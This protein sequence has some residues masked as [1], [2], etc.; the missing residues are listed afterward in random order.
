[1][2]SPKELEIA[3][4]NTKTENFSHPNQI[5]FLLLPWVLLGI[6]F[7]F[8]RKFAAVSTRTKNITYFSMGAFAIL[9]ELW[10]DVSS[11]INS[12]KTTADAMHEQ[13]I[14]GFDFCRMNMYI[15]GLFLVIRKPEMVKWIAAT[16]LFGGYSTLIDHYGQHSINP[17]ADIHSLM[18]HAVILSVIPAIT[19][20]MNKT[21]YKVRNL[22]QA[23]LF[24]WTLVA[25]MFTV[26]VYNPGSVAGEL[27]KDRMADNMLVGWAPWPA[28]M[29]LWILSV[30]MLEWAYF[31]IFR[32]IFWRTYLQKMTFGQTFSMEWP[33]DKKQWYGFKI[34]N[35][36]GEKN[37]KTQ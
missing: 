17:T 6:V 26:N 29:F 12:N 21:N 35:R 20:T 23:H 2:W 14:A 9:W 24:N 30:M 16:A 13:F 36:N 10:F 27:T 37:E 19:I 1:M 18:T 4:S 31:I 22:V 34:I 11:I 28:N 15:L 5:I 7:F 32:I 3:W 33:A 8:R 25:I